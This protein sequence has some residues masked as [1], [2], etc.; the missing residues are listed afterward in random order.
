[1]MLLFAVQQ[2][3]AARTRGGRVHIRWKRWL[4]VFVALILF[5]LLMD[6]IVMPAYTRHGQAIDVPDVTN[7]TFET[8][9]SVLEEHKL[10]AVKGG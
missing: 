9:R 2:A 3:R 7:M 4:A 1:M 10:K 6:R 5:Y 8:A